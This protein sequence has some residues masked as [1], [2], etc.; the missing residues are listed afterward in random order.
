MVMHRHP[1]AVRLS[2]VAV[3]VALLLSAGCARK[4]YLAQYSFADRTLAL[5][6]LDPPSPELLTGYYDIRPSYDP[7]RTAVRI[8]GG[9]AKEVEAHR[10]SARLD[11]ATRGVNL[12]GLLA[13]RT[14]ERASLYLGTHPSSDQYSADFVLEISLKH[15]G[16]DARPTTAAWL[17]TR[18]EAVLVDRRS[19]REIWS[20]DVHGSDRMTPWVHG[21]RDIPSSII[22]AATI[23]TISVADFREA[24]D[25]LATSSSN[26]ITNE[27][28]DKLRDVRDR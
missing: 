8:G 15:F 2:R 27:L 18:A 24:L 1:E 23:S 16:I 11:S 5:V 19:G 13:K 22:T 25:Q 4:H 3:A 20:V 12:E 14:L 21:N 6:F 7:V 28:R 17:Y 10:A 9:V 26:A